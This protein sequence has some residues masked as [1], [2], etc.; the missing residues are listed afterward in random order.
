MTIRTISPATAQY[1]YTFDKWSP[2]VDVVKGD[3]T[4]TATYEEKQ[5]KYTITFVQDGGVEIE[6]HLL[7]RDEVP[8][9][10]NVPTRTGYILQ[11]SPNDPA[12]VTGDQ[13]YT[14]TWL[15]EP[16]ETYTITFKNYDGTV[17]KKKSDA[18]ANAVFTVEAETMP[19]DADVADPTKTATPEYE[20]AFTGWKPALAS[21]S[22]NATYVAQFTENPRQYTIN[23][24]REDRDAVYSVWR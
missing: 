6:R 5:I 19:S 11:W 14:A 9:C 17:L 2:G 15:P 16:P 20:Y 13:T 24:Y 8:V 7:A 18:S 1:T 10:E 23:F 3:V 22:S 4:Y 12:P 21:A